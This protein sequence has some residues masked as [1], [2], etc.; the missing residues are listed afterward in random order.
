[1]K[2]DPGVIIVYRIVTPGHFSSGSIFYVLT[3]LTIAAKTQISVADLIH[4]GTVVPR[5]YTVLGHASTRK[6]TQSLCRSLE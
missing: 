5:D 4:V 3:V 6:Q 1:M 2:S